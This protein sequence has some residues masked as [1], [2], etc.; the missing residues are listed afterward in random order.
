MSTAEA[1]RVTAIAGV[2]R[3][4]RYLLVTSGS[5]VGNAHLAILSA[6]VLALLSGRQLLVDHPGLQRV[7]EGLPFE[8][9]QLRM[10]PSERR[11]LRN[12]SALVIDQHTLS[13]GWDAPEVRYMCETDLAADARPVLTLT[14]NQWFA[15]LLFQNPYHRTEMLR[16]LELPAA[17]SLLGQKTSD[18]SQPWRAFAHLARS[19]FLPSGE[20]ARHVAR[21]LAP[22]GG[23]C[24]VGLHL[25]VTTNTY[26]EARNRVRGALSTALGCTLPR[27][28]RGSRLY[29]SS[30]YSHAHQSL[31]NLTAG[32]GVRIAG[33][34][35]PM[36]NQ[37][38]DAEGVFSA[39]TDIW[40]L[41]L[42]K[43]LV[44]GSYSTFGRT[45]ALLSPS[46]DVR[47]SERCARPRMAL[48]PCFHGLRLFAHVEPPA[49]HAS[50]SI[51]RVWWPFLEACAS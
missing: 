21:A 45:A 51:G 32:R 22:L 6:Y 39:C 43:S 41:S 9:W 48:D 29:F 8:P 26:A 27:L 30:M 46:T 23:P 38:W 17:P 34:A 1:A 16:L 25:R 36:D 24:D 15:P 5:G 4:Q 50:A 10:L 2:R 3:T 44:V 12:A 14:S 13:L 33:T 35:G 49:N 37:T 7:Y 28:A 11:L 47:F 42:S 40:A 19:L 31:A 20:L 18:A